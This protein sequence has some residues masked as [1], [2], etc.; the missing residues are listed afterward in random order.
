MKN[1]Y[2]RSI[3]GLLAVLFLFTLVTIPAPVFAA[4]KA[5]VNPGSIFYAF[6]IL[7]EKADLAFTFNKEKRVQK[8]IT[9]TGERLAE[10]EDAA[11][12]GKPDAVEKAMSGYQ[13]GISSAIV[14]AKNINDKEK[15][16][17]LLSGISDNVSKQQDVLTAVYDKVPE[18]SKD[19]VKKAI[20]I[21]VLEQ[22]KATEEIVSIQADISSDNQEG[23][24]PKL[25][26]ETEKINIVE[27]Q[28]KDK[29]KKEIE[30]APKPEKDIKAII[31][32]KVTEIIVPST[33]KQ[34]QSNSDTASGDSMHQSASSK[35][36]M[37]GGGMSMG[38][39]TS[40][41]HPV[42]PTTPATPATPSTNNNSAI[43]ATPAIPANPSQSYFSSISSLSFAPS[44]SSSFSSLSS[45][46]SVG[47]S[48]SSSV[49]SSSSSSSIATSTPPI[50][51]DNLGPWITNLSILPTSINPGDLVTFTTTAE[52]PNGI[53][54]IVVDIK[55][56]PCTCYDSDYYLRPN[57][58][59]SGATSGTQT[60]TETIDHGTSPT[61]LGDYEIVT[62]RAVDS[63]GNLST[64]YPNGT[65]T[66]AKQGTHTLTIPVIKVS[67]PVQSSSSSSSSSVSSSSSSASSASSSSSS[68]L[69]V[70]QFILKW[71]TLGTGD[72]QF[73]DP[74]RVAIDNSGNVY[75]ADATNYRIQ[76]FTPAGIFITKWGLE[77]TGNGQFDLP[78]GITVDNG[79]NVYVSD[80]NNNRIQKFDANGAFLSAFGNYGTANG[81][82][83]HPAGIALDTSGNL[84]VV[85][86]DNHRIQKFDS[87]GI[88]ILKWG[89]YGSE[90]GQFN[91]PRGI[92][93]DLNNNVFIADTD[94]HR[95]QKFT[96]DGVFVTKW[97]SLGQY[98]DG[99]FTFPED[100]AVDMAGNVYVTGRDDHRVQKF[101]NDGVFVAKLGGYGTGDGQF[102]YPEGIA[103]DGAGNIYIGDRSNHRIQKFK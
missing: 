80:R 59:F 73:K 11:V 61:I 14:E 62:I 2:L 53:G 99:T 4:T 63:F 20:A 76:K 74:W 75:V 15:T 26:K 100:V 12:E 94:S 87:N 101:T 66:N 35:K 93:I 33:Q 71:G 83:N 65:V 56:P 8:I 58:N 16:K 18:A 32:P 9:N 77:G 96:S 3:N 29:D 13:E 64:Y 72:G 24:A 91:T 19:A 44:N 21:S 85:D 89:I 7:L 1:I 90:N 95:I 39:I 70:P 52:D 98:S 103:V 31:V 82:F 25:Q 42:N 27:N 36:G 57:F 17:K 67:V 6:D 50:A 86:A 47:S 46:S 37:G 23:E 54:S 10:A 41:A 43:P 51:N 78:R 92:A 5:G 79:G 38:V 84:Y 30:V 45:S 97:G 40:G 81:Q 68:S 48:S 34:V 102:Q 60:F 49:A 88:F 22:E 55:Y 28:E 69:S